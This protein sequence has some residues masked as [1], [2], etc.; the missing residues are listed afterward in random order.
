MWEV[1]LDALIDSAKILPILFLTYL[2][3]EYFLHRKKESSMGFVTQ[4]R[5]R[6][7]LFGALLG[8]FPQCGFSAAIADFY[9]KKYVTIGTLIAV[10]VATSDEAI[11]ILLSYPTRY[12]ELLILI[13]I[14]LVLAII[15]GYSVDLI[16]KNQKFSKVNSELCL[17]EKHEH[18]HIHHDHCEHKEGEDENENCCAD[19]IFVTALKQ[20]LEI[21]LFLLVA[22][23]II[24]LSIYFIGEQNLQLLLVKDSILLPFI[25]PL[26]GI[27]PNCFASVFLVQMFIQNIIP[28]SAMLGGLVTGAGVG[29]LVLYKKN[30]NT[31]QNIIITLGILI[32]GVVVGLIGFAIGF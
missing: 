10:F 5:K 17:S 29:L 11:I 24:S 23:V 19:N 16:F 3:V 25:T 32:L 26:I 21:F 1:L 30:K 8:I 13:A 12:V 15:I 22:N 18:C 7:P 28:F 6:G 31:K 4:N 9:S 14:K 20:T 2:L 27:I